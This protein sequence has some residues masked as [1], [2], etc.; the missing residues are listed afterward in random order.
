MDYISK[1]KLS[2]SE[3]LLKFINNELLPGTDI[4][5][6]N[7]GMVLINAYMNYHQ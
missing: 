3:I 2:I 1:G 6:K 7:F 5:P 4:E